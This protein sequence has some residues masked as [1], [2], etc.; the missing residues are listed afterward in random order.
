MNTQP[1]CSTCGKALPAGAPGG[2]CPECL[3]KVGLGS[4][5]DI[6]ADTEAGARRTAFVP[7]TVAELAPRFPQLGIL[8]FIGQGGMGAVYKARQ[9]ELDRIVALKILPPDIGQDAAFAE[10]FTREARALAKLN[11][12]GIV[13]IHEFGRA[14][15]LYFFVMEFVDGVNL[16][17]LLHSGRVSARE[18]LAIVP[19]ICDALQYAHDAGIVHRDI[20]PENILLDRRGRVKVADFGL[21][22]IMGPERGSVSRSDREPGK[23]FGPLKSSGSGEAAAGRRPALQDLTDAGKV[24]GTPQYMSPEQIQAPG[25]VDHRA[26]IYAL[27]VVFYQMLT[28]ELPGHHIAPPSQKVHIDVRLDEVV[29]RALEQSPGRR[30]QQASALKTQ[31]ETIAATPPPAPL[32][33]GSASA[34]LRS[35]LQ[36]AAVGVLLA[37]ILSLVG[38]IGG[39]LFMAVAAYQVGKNAQV[40]MEMANREAAL[41]DQ[42][43]QEDMARLQAE[44]ERLRVETNRH[45][46]AEAAREMLSQWQQAMGVCT[47]ELHRRQAEA[48]Q[49]RADARAAQ[50]RAKWGDLVLFGLPVLLALILAGSA[51]TV[52]GARQMLR[53]GR[54]GWANAGCVLAMLTPPGFLLGLPFGIWGLVL[55]AHPEVR[56]AFACNG[57]SGAVPKR[58]DLVKRPGWV[59]TQASLVLVFASALLVGTVFSMLGIA[60]TS[61]LIF[62]VLVLMAVAGPLLSLAMVRHRN[63][64]VTRGFLR[65]CAIVGAL[66]SLPLIGFSGFFLMAMASQ[67]DGWHPAPDE[68]VIVPLIWLGAVLL[69]ACSWGL[70]RAIHPLRECQQRVEKGDLGS[71]ETAPGAASAGLRLGTGR[72]V[73]SKAGVCG[74]PWVH[75]ASGIDPTTGRPRVA[76]GIVAVGPTAVGV[77][78]VGLRA[79]GFLPVGLLAIGVA[80]VGLIA[81]GLLA[82]GFLAAGVEVSGV[83]SFGVHQAVGLVAISMGRAV[84]LCALAPQPVGLLPRPLGLGAALLLCAAVSGLIALI[85]WR[86]SRATRSAGPP[87]ARPPLNQRL[88]LA[89][90]V[91]LSVALLVT[92]AATVVTFLLPESYASAARVRVERELKAPTTDWVAGHGPYFIQTEFEVIQSELVLRRVITN[93][94]LCGV[95]GQRFAGGRRLSGDAAFALLRNSLELRVVRSTSLVEIRAYAVAPA[96]SAQLANAVAA[97][98]SDL[99]TGAGSDGVNMVYHVEI[100][101]RA[102]PALHPVRPN[103]PLNICI[104]AAAGGVLGC[105]AGGF[106]LLMSFPT[107]GRVIYTALAVL[108]IPAA[109]ILAAVA[110]SYSANPASTLLGAPL[111]VTNQLPGPTNAAALKPIPPEVFERWAATQAWFRDA[112]KQLKPNDPAAYEALDREYQA[113]TLAIK[114]LIR[115]TVLEPLSQQQEAAAE[116]FRAATAAHH[117]AAAKAAADEVNRL[118][119]QIERLMS[120][121]AEPSGAATSQ[122]VRDASNRKQMSPR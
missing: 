32:P 11:H 78:A 30:Y 68:A 8:E 50:L 27:G 81:L 74:I 62:A 51:V 18:A 95:W 66:T 119:I 2:L 64:A 15:G 79:Y 86:T 77:V 80:P 28:G 6:G 73:R 34:R 17:Q 59:V 107:S 115:G 60:G 69:P 84:G 105:I 26:D 120:S 116:S 19:Q 48:M 44:H 13:T 83:I 104:G 89:F 63:P 106:V 53:M 117:E 121:P 92:L 36:V 23:A 31:V 22:K 98:Y 82:V 57:P 103:K 1:A 49:N 109:L 65:F 47:A 91:A 5:V 40:R 39:G 54:P 112:E 114:E 7:P 71:P 9:K 46:E 110:V 101:D 122:P 12:P 99:R 42:V 96:E 35:Q 94:D 41:V 93:L 100:V 72:D 102:V 16:R 52:L 90:L 43:F 14:D 4:G 70:W 85:G 75:V 25:E 37:G 45:P 21:A 108:L 24:M 20:K 118:R 76:K 56:G 29:L 88:K 55:L 38:T 87:P 3:I 67:Q 58:S 111:P 97:A 61:I 113:R 10:R 33:A